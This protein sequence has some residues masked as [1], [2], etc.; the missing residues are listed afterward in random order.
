MPTALSSRAAVLGD[1]GVGL[2]AALGGRPRRARIDALGRN[3]WPSAG[4]TLDLDFVNQRGYAYGQGLGR[5]RDLVTLS[6]GAGGTVV[7]CTGVIVATNAPRFDYDP[8]TLAC[9]GLLIEEQRTN[10]LTRSSDVSHANWPKNLATVTGNAAT[11][12]DGTLS[13]SKLIPNAGAVNGNASQTLTVTPATAYT[14]SFDLKAAE[15]SVI[16]FVTNLTGSFIR[17]SFDANTSAATATG[18]GFTVT[19]RSIGG[20]ISRF[21]ATATS[22]AATVSASFQLGNNSIWVGDGASG[23]YV[24]AVQVEAGAFATSY[25]PTTSAA[26]TRTAD[27]PQITGSKFKGFFNPIEGTVVAA[28]T[29]DLTLAGSVL[30]YFCNGG[31]NE[32]IGALSNNA[33]TTEQYTLFAGGLSQGAG[34]GG[35]VATTVRSAFGYR[36]GDAAVAQNGGVAVGFVPPALSTLIDRV[37]IGYTNTALATNGHVQRLTYFPRRLSDDELRGLTR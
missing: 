15:Q 2:G 30:Y 13:M 24:G 11:G 10:M 36:Q 20:G 7:D 29:R 8:L 35:A 25:I 28:A 22:G 3:R 21:T 6:G 27:N 14:L 16:S 23:I 26:V 19:G 12:S 4:A 17:C 32:R 1:F 33:A 37:F 34:V 5:I 31:G 18:A 9:K